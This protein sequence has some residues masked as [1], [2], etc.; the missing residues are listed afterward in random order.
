MTHKNLNI[1]KKLVYLSDMLIIDVLTT[2]TCLKHRGAVFD[3]VKKFPWQPSS[4]II[5]FLG[6]YI[7]I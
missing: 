4:D 1:V 5:W 3:D 6:I 7:D 2:K